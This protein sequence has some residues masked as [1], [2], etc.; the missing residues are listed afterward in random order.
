[1]IPGMFSGWLQEII[2]Y[3]HFFVWVLLATIPSFLIVKFIPLE[4]EFG[5]KTTVETKPQPKPPTTVE[6]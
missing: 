5:R 3:Q 4:A 1:M 6:S 2:G